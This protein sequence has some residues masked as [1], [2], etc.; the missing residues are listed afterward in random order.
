MI[1]TKQ[2]KTITANCVPPENFEAVN[3]LSWH[4]YHTAYYELSPY[5]I[6][7]DGNEEL[8]NDGG[9]IFENF[10]QGSKVYNETKKS[11]QYA[12]PSR[13]GNPAYLWFSYPATTFVVND[14]ILP[15]YFI[16]RNAL[17]NCQ[18]PVRYPEHKKFIKPN[19]FIYFLCNVIRK[20]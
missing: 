7:T 9:I 2:I 14:I 15:S 12:H 11:E 3:I 19:S 18:H 8:K 10:W 17:F 13:I 5:V 16:W 20:I 4:D 6:R 1:K